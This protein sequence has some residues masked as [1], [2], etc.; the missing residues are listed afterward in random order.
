MSFA[1]LQRKFDVSGHKQKSVYL[2]PDETCVAEF[3]V[4]QGNASRKFLPNTLSP[5]L[6]PVI[7]KISINV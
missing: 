5:G 2:R 7:L 1:E 4:Y 3:S 6:K